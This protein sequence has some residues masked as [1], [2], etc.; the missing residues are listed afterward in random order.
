SHF[1]ELGFCEQTNTRVYELNKPFGFWIILAWNLEHISHY[2]SGF[3]WAFQN[4]VSISVFEVAESKHFFFTKG[5]E[6]TQN[7]ADR[8]FSIKLWPP[9]ESTRSMLV[10]RMTSSLSSESYFSR[11]YGLLSKEEAA[12]NAKKI[13]D[14]AF[15]AANDHDSR[16]PN[17]DGGSAV[18]LYAKESSKL[19]LEALKQGP[20]AAKTR[21][22]VAREAIPETIEVKETVFDISRGARGFVDEALAMELLRPLE[23]PGN[24]YTKICFSNRSFGVEA[25][26]VAERVLKG[27]QEHL[28]DVDLA[29]FI[30]GR[31]EDEALEVMSIFSS[32]LE[33]CVLRSLNL[34]NNALG[35][36]G[37]RAFGSLLKS[38]ETLEE[39][40]FLNNGISAEAAR[41]I[42]ELLPS[43][44][45]I[46][47]LHFFNNMTGD[48]G[49]EALSELVK[50]CITLEDFRCSSARVGTQGG[51][52]LAGAL[53][54]G[55]RLKKLDLMDN[56]FGT[57][58]GV[59]VSRAISG[60][61][62]LTEVYLSY[63]NF[64]DEGAIAIANSLKEGAPSLRVLEI[65]GNDITSKAAPALAECLTVKKLLTKFDASE[66]ELKDEG[67]IIICKALLE[68]H[69][70]L[71]EL[72]L[73]TNAITG[74]GA[75]AAAEAVANKPDFNVLNIDANFMSEE[76]IETVKDVLRKGAK[77]V[78]VLGSLEDNDEE[79]GGD[80]DES[81][82]DNEESKGDN[83][84]NDEQK[85]SDG[86]N[87]LE[88]K[89]QNLKV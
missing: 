53:A 35:E 80:D 7:H 44:E 81:N 86:D 37:I 40:Y 54:E 23:E 13:E 5:M 29:D 25:A 20:N 9:S 72:N 65:A 26:R 75:K 41:A 21:E 52:A 70:H 83:E 60:H 14:I 39:L 50:N 38:Q 27:V 85:N 61:L 55:S 87:E 66:N 16:Y 68:G 89:L 18:Q 24:C 69:D 33:G 8:V 49:A 15:V 10:E 74:I 43:V 31:P 79:G 58:G 32:V 4:I 48:D 22:V 59:A 76:G 19:M 2:Y 63:L 17:A 77:G 12:E 30:A 84:D 64:E 11:R 67:S 47:T 3:I 71:K 6:T 45:R 34:S 73:S 82:G 51:I 78:S 1:R 56:M 36:K 28:T 46:K 42:C 88:E 62:D 57:T